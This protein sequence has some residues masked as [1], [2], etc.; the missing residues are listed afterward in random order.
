MTNIS[1]V[2][3]GQAQLDG[4][5]IA[6]AE[7][8]NNNIEITNVVFLPSS[9]GSGDYAVIQFDM[10]GTTYTTVDGGVAVVKKLKQVSEANKFPVKARLIELKGKSG[11]LYHDLVDWV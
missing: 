4:E 11:R 9:M 3:K 8:M 1:E 6:N 10:N 7:I 2:T 5:Q